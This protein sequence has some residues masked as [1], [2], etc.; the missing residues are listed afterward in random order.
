[1][2]ACVTIALEGLA[3]GFAVAVPVGPVGLLTIRQSLHHGRLTGFVT[4][5]GAATADAVFGLIAAIGLTA[6]V[7]FLA[8]HQAPLQIAGGIMMLAIGVQAMRSHPPTGTNAPEPPDLRT[9][10]IS[11]VAITLTNPMT[12][13]GF[14]ALF[15]GLKV[16]PFG[17]P[18][19]LILTTGI[20]VGSTI[21][22]LILSSIAGWLGERIDS[23][24]LRFINIV[25]GLAIA[26]FGAWQ[27]LRLAL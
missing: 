18:H 24:R 12:I 8:R 25:A 9:A 22:W 15:T 21:W 2:P 19:V 13:I 7:A 14:I 20:F 4:G 17:L 1:V 16:H 10:Y 26:V 11:T 5:L 23:A 3:I 6:V 27:L